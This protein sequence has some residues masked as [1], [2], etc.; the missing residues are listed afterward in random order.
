MI[1][2]SRMCCA[3]KRQRAYNLRR[4]RKFYVIVMPSCHRLKK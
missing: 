4:S 3:R 2:R 1:R